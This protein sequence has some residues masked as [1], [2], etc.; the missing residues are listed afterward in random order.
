MRA[1]Y[2]KVQH[3]MSLLFGRNNNFTSSWRQFHE[4]RRAHSF[5]W[6]RK[7][8]VVSRRK[9]GESLCRRVYDYMIASVMA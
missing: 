1:F 3:K 6:S 7:R 8:H 2:V 9:T 4:Q 5:V